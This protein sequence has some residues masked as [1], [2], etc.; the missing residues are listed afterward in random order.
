MQISSFLFFS[1]ITTSDQIRITS[2]SWCHLKDRSF[3]FKK[4][5]DER[6]KSNNSYA[7]ILS[8]M[9]YD[10]Y[11]SCHC[12]L[13]AF[14]LRKS[15][16]EAVEIVCARLRENAVCYRV[17]RKLYQRFKTFGNFNLEDNDW[18]TFKCIEKV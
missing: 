17:C 12:L 13:F 1:T 7:T 3:V 6:S 9:A 4:S 2:C 16:V 11:H 18:K 8:N 10:K 5:R 15:T 14:Q